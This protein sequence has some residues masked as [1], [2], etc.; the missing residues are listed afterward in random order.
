MT[1]QHS[2]FN[3]DY[4]Y[5]PGI[6]LEE[7]LEVKGMTQAELAK[8]SGITTKTINSIIKGSASISSETAVILECVLGKS[9]SYWLGLD[10]QYQIHKA[11]EEN[12]EHL[13]KEIGLL[14]ELD[15]KSLI[16]NGWIKP[17]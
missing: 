15:L 10:S 6:F 8:R 1:N 12:D 14:S 2:E 9:A 4:S 5:H 16:K 11:K 7:E 17:F 3:P 13:R